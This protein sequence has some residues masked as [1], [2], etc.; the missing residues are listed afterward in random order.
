MFET[1]LPEH[2]HRLMLRLSRCASAHPASRCRLGTCSRIGLHLTI[3]PASSTVRC[4]EIRCCLEHWTDKTWLLFQCLALDLE[5]NFSQKGSRAPGQRS[6][7]RRASLFR[8]WTNCYTVSRQ[9]P[10]EGIQQWLSS[11]SRDLRHLWPM[12]VQEPAIDWCCRIW[13]CCNCHSC[14]ELW[15]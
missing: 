4:S 10:S 5:E 15:I 14:R 8:C 11:L 6:H 13:L 3:L 9:C 12:F 2:I 1:S 7:T